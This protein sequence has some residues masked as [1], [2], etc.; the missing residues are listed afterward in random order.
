MSEDFNKYLAI[1]NHDI[2]V[3]NNMSELKNYVASILY[4]N[5]KKVEL[6]QQKEKIIKEVR[7]I[8]KRHICNPSGLKDGWHIDCW[9]NEDISKLNEDLGILDKENK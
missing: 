3:A 2:Q 8:L 1:A 7:E 6:L 5:D 9:N 4:D